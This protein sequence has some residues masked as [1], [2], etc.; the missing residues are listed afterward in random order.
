MST[1]FLHRAL[2]ASAL[3]A[4]SMVLTATADD[5]SLGWDFE[6]GCLEHRLEMAQRPPSRGTGQ[7][8]NEAT[9]ADSRNW[10]PN[11]LVN[12]EHIKIALR[13]PDLVAAEAE[14]VATYTVRPIGV[15][16]ENLKLNAEGLKIET[17]K[18]N[19]AD[20]EHYSDGKVLTMKFAKPL[21]A[22]KSTSIE[23]GY[24]VSRPTDGMTF[25]PAY[26]DRAGYGPQVHT[27]GET[28]SNNYWFPCH[29]FPN[30]RQS[31]ELLVDVPKGMSVSGNGKLVDHSTKGDRE[32][33]NYLQ[34][35]PHAAYLV[36]LVVGDLEAVPLK[37]PL[38]GVPMHVWVPKDRAG[39]VE[40]TYGRTDRM[41]A[42]FEKVFGQKYPWAR[43]DQL[44][45]RNFGAGGMENTSVTNMYP[46]AILSETA[47]KEED[48]DGL[49]SHEL[50]HQWTGDFI[51]CK[52]WAH[53]WLNEGWATYGTALWME[54]RDGPDGYFESVLDNAGVARND[55]TENTVGM[56]SPIYK[57]AG[58]TFGRAA[59]PYPKGSSILHM[60]R[61]ML[62]DEIFF[63]GV[64]A[65]MA[66]YGLSTAETSDF[67]IAMEQ[68]SGLGLEWFFDQWCMRPGSPNITAKA[69]YDGATRML[70]IKADQTQKI[71]ERTPAMRVRT[72]ICVRTASGEKTVPWEWRE[73]SADIEIPL[74][75][76]PVWV[77]FDPRLNTLKTLKMEWPLEWLRAQAKSG[78]TMASKRQAVEA[79]RT[80]GSP[81]TIAVLEQIA[82]DETGRRRIRG[83]CID[84]ISD[85]K[86]ADSV[87]SITRLL[88]TPPQDPRVR[89]MLTSA[90][91]AL[92][93]EKAIPILTKTLAEDPGELCRK[94]AIDQL[95]KLEAKESADA[96]LAAAEL[97]S[98][99]EQIRSAALR[100]LAK[101]EVSKA[102]PLAL[103]YGSLGGYD[104][105]RGTAIDTAAKLV[106]KDEKD[107]QRIAAIEQLIFWLDD[108]ERGARRASGEALA[109]LKAKAA[110]P[111]LEAMA[112]SDP[113]PDVR[114][115]ATDWVKR[116]N[117]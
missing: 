51:T 6:S 93:K 79:L 115:A 98:H 49:I 117:G 92:P 85:F 109:T 54:E 78:P 17:V 35:K 69:T 1:P 24:K 89:S 30:V 12:Y 64:R 114:E 99:Q 74:D 15:P 81:D 7:A 14:G 84:A 65:Y 97:P 26:P 10:P 61:E 83:E 62:G 100:A 103:K 106:P 37:S 43:Y 88:E 5:S 33:W 55:K 60:L 111:R 45:V 57:N 82:K 28:E 102:L 73:K 87:A 86:N 25:S 47:A 13:F 34:E 52:S 95:A 75:G 44:L 46:N 19:G 40:R 41:I 36:S 53:I 107:P 80:D 59:N 16:V 32:I 105:S 77:A 116:I 67:R 38:S 63:K 56:V 23:V 90:V 94:N 110:I 29:D 68:A 22:D 104:R 3:L 66:K 58:E 70:R 21:P 113:D 8:W 101:F 27:Q 18:V 96:I 71:D 4:A 2:A 108:P 20:T 42:L 91:G 112:A 76:P 50:C 11:P 9:G 72:P 48:L 39:D 31:T